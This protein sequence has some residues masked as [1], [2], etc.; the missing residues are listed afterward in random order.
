M[1]PGH[2]RLE[3]LKAIG[4]RHVDLLW[5]DME[6]QATSL[7][8]LRQHLMVARLKD[9]LGIVH[10]AGPGT[11]PGEGQAGN[12]SSAQRR[13]RAEPVDSEPVVARMLWSIRCSL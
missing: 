6:H 4:K 13:R 7:E 1:G 3:Q 11:E 2:R 8:V 12:M 9:T 5:F 10:I